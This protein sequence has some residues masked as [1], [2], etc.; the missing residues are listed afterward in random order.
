MNAAICRWACSIGLLLPTLALAQLAGRD[1]A[2]GLPHPRDPQRPGAVVLHGGGRVTDDVFNYFVARAGGA[3]ARIVFVPCAG[4]RPTDYTTEANYLSVLSTRYSAWANLKR[5]GH[6]ADF[7]F[8]YTDDPTDAN[9]A[10]FVQS[11]EQATG[12]WFSG[13]LQSRLNY[14]FVEFP[15]ATRFQVA[16]RGV[17]ERGGVIGGTSAGM[18]AMPEI[19][20]LYQSQD[21]ASA[22][23]QAVTAHGLGLF[24]RAVVEQHFDAWNGRLERFTGLLRDNTKLNRLAGR[25]NAGEK[26]MGIGVEERT[27]LVVNGPRLSVLGDSCVHLFLKTNN[28]KTVTWHELSP[29]DSG[30]LRMGSQGPSFT[31]EEL[32]LSR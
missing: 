20:T 29:G 10:Q 26:M 18:A 32:V 27:A 2:L 11:L 5:N 7:R 23:M 4:Y 25:I 3:K 28:G 12:V 22:P 21:E 8:L 30:E 15:E 17:L 14:R 24:N 16:L 31:S 13:G 9:D 6:V 1:T 19:M